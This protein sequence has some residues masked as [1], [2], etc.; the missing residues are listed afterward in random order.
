M[1]DRAAPVRAAGAGDDGAPPRPAFLITIDVEEDDAWSGAAAVRTRNAGFLPRFQA[2]C[3]R[4]GLPPTYLVDWTMATS[5]EFQEFGRAVLAGGRGE[6]GMHL[7]AWTTPPILPLTGTDHRHKP[8]LIDFPEPVM[9]AKVT[10]ATRTLQ[11]VFGIAPVSH[12][13]GRWMMDETYARILVEHGYLADCSVTPHVSW[14]GTSGAPGGRGP[15]DY[16][17]YPEHPYFVDPRAL[18]RAG[19]SPLLEVPMT[20]APRRYG[21]LVGGARAVLSRGGPA[22]RVAGRL[23]PRT[24][25]LR[26]NGRNRREMLEL[27]GRALRSGRDHVEFM[28]HSSELMPGGS[29]YF[30]TFRSVEALYDD[31]EA[32]FA[33]AAGP[34][35]GLTLAAYRAGFAARAGLRSEPRTGRENPCTSAK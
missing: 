31:I 22:G 28:L 15:R 3:D 21:P 20:I 26:P 4:Y 33:F 12:R 8:F 30:R 24:S 19:E 17:D 27:A 25:W 1:S 34:F 11:D 7:H 13:A 5:P 35:E 32:L 29:P 18:H 9:A 16:T 10:T 6:I 23:W 2:L 14:H